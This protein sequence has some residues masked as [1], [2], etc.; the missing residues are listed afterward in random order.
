MN[1][2]MYVSDMSEVMR[3]MCELTS[4]SQISFAENV[5]DCLKAVRF[6]VFSWHPYMCDVCLLT[7][8]GHAFHT[9]F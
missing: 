4:Q 9:T 5:F 8:A 7:F 2:E 6:H 1:G 3:Q